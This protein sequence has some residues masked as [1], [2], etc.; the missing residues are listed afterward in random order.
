MDKEES[1]KKKSHVV[2][3]LHSL[4]INRLTSYSNNKSYSS[5]KWFA[6]LL[7]PFISMTS[8]KDMLEITKA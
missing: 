3:C 5:I 4:F 2:M 6:V 1:K 7:I 8:F